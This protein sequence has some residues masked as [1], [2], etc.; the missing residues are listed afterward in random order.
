MLLHQIERSK[1]Y[2]KKAKRLWRWNASGKGNY[3][4]RW[5]K[6]QN[7]RSGGGMPAWFEGGQTPLTQRIPKLRWFKRYYKLVKEYTPVNL[8]VL[9][10]N[11]NIKS[12]DVINKAKLKELNIIKKETELVKI[13]WKWELTKKLIF[14]GI[15]AFSASAKEKILQAWGEIK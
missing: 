12:W 7:A 10:K 6:W 14:E 8:L 11:E 5:I 2:N 3:S 9:E 15:D 13:L 1:G 4:T